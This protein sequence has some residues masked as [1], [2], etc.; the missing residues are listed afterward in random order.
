MRLILLVAAL[1]AL[2]ISALLALI[3]GFGASAAVAHLGQVAYFEYYPDGPQYLAVPAS[4]GALGL[5]RGGIWTV[6]AGSATA[7]VLMLRKAA[8]RA[9]GRYLK[10]EAGHAYQALRCTITQLPRAQRALGAAV[11]LG[12][13]GLQL[14]WLLTD[15]LSPDE[16]VSYDAFVHQG[17]VAITSFYPI[18]NNHL[19][20]NL[21]CWPL[22]LLLP[23][24]ARLIMRLPSLLAATLGTGMGYLLL[25]HYRGF[26][27]ATLATALFGLSTVSLT[28]A[29]SGRGYFLQLTCLLAA[30]FAVYCLVTQGGCRRLAWAT[31]ILGSTAGLYTVPTFALPLLALA[32]GL[33]VASARAAAS[34]R[35]LITQT[36]A[37]FLTIGLL[38]ALLYFPVGCISGWTRLLANRYLQAHSLAAFLISSKAYLYEAAGLLYGPPRGALLL[39]A[40]LT[41]GTPAVL[42]RAEVGP[43]ARWLAGLCWALVLVPVPLMLARQFYIPARV[44]LFTTYFLYVLLALAADWAWRQQARRWLSLVATGA[45]MVIFAVKLMA[46]VAQVP[47]LLRS[48][49]RAQEVARA[50]TWLSR[51]PAGPVFVGASYHGLLF[52]HLGLLEHRSLPLHYA[53]RGPMRYVVWGKDQPNSLPE[54]AKSLPLQPGYSDEMVFI[55]RLPSAK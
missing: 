16:L 23:G 17:P 6:I 39:W 45:I 43:R 14:G 48:R 32:A 24:Q 4:D 54:W 44:L 50:Y 8:F 28:Y 29:A 22:K 19:F 47:V 35:E 38:T 41:L 30:F 49:A 46:I 36:G 20:Y 42:A 31:F 9:E 10:Q 37:A 51:Q 25:T 40:A 2:A 3:Y 11:L 1:G 13:L 12:L 53:P 55:Y 21:L 15:S 27:V 18:P 34:Q 52:Y 26:R 7:S 33:L 5:L